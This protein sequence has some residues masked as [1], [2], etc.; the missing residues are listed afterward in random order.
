MKIILLIVS[1]CLFYYAFKLKDLNDDTPIWKKKISYEQ[2][3]WISSI[4]CLIIFIS[5]NIIII[6][7]PKS[8][9]YLGYTFLLIHMIGQW[10]FRNKKVKYQKNTFKQYFIDNILGNLMYKSKDLT[11]KKSIFDNI[12][13]NRNLSILFLTLFFISFH[14]KIPLF[15]KLVN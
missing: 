10:F 2:F 3:I 5:S 8:L 9:F 13:I 12:I 11:S 6:N 14:Y 4:I 7:E 1:I 15:G